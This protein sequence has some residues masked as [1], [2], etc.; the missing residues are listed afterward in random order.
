MWGSKHSDPY[1][2]MEAGDV[3][4]GDMSDFA[5]KTVR[6]GFIRKVFGA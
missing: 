3:S 1:A 2:Q 4:L 5:D 6:R